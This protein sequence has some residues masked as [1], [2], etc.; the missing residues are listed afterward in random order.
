VEFTK[1]MSC[2]SSPSKSRNTTPEPM[3]SGRYF[4]PNAPLVWRNEILAAA[5]TSTKR[6]PASC[7]AASAAASGSAAASA[8]FTEC[9][10]PPD[11]PSAERAL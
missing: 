5:V 2:L 11:R 3:V 10:R 7:A 9:R 8:A 6:T 1:K 4:W